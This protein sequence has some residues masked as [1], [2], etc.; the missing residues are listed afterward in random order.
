[1]KRNDK[2]RESIIMNEYYLYTWQQSSKKSVRAFIK[3]N[4]KEIDKYI[5]EVMNKKHGK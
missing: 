4:R 5:D 2:E 3:E 1:M